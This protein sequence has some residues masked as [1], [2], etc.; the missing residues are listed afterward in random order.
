MTMFVS[1]A[2]SILDRYEAKR[3]EAGLEFTPPEEK[4]D[5]GRYAFPA[6]LFEQIYMGVVTGLLTE[7]IVHLLTFTYSGLQQLLPHNTKPKSEEEQVASLINE[8]SSSTKIAGEAIKKLQD[9]GVKSDEA[10]AA[11]DLL[12]EAIQEEIIAKV[13]KSKASQSEPSCK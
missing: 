5:L 11:V 7:W 8:L 10:Q 9:Q 2:Q 3:K 6:D 4:A 12:M 1:Q 13:Q